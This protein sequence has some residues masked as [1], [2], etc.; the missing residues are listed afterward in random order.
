MTMSRSAVSWSRWGVGV[1]SVVD[2]ELGLKLV[3]ME[4]VLEEMEDVVAL[5]AVVVFVVVVSI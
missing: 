4:V 1:G 2:V 3:A 5:G